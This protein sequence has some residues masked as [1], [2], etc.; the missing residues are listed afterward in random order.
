MEYE[1]IEKFVCEGCRV[2]VKRPMLSEIEKMERSNR[3]AKT[4]KMV[5]QEYRQELDEKRNT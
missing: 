1:V 4:M 5:V 2:T 3:I